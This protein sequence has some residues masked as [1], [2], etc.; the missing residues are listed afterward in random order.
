MGGNGVLAARSNTHNLRTDMPGTSMAAP[1]V[2]GALALS[3]SLS[4]SADLEDIMKSSAEELE[5]HGRDSYADVFG[6]GLLRADAL[7]AQLVGKRRI[8]NLIG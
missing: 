6:A 2:S 4:G 3:L 5:W 8:Q 1:H 7:I